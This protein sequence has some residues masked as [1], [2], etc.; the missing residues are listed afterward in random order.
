MAGTNRGTMFGP[1]IYMADA[2]RATGYCKVLTPADDTL[3]WVKRRLQLTEA[4][5]LE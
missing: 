3:C 4:G 2:V 1:G 5:S